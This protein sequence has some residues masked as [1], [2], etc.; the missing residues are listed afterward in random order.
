M[1]GL[2]GTSREGQGGF[3]GS[4]GGVEPGE[5]TSRKEKGGHSSPCEFKVDQEAGV[6][7]VWTTCRV[8]PPAIRSL[9]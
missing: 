5:V 4:W 6:A 7:E 1:S 2:A 3:R 8:G 9:F